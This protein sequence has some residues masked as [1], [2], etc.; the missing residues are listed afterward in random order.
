MDRTIKYFDLLSG[1][2][3]KFN[4]SYEALHNH[5][6][7]LLN[8]DACNENDGKIEYYA[9]NIART[10]IMKE[11]K[12]SFKIEYGRLDTVIKICKLGKW[13]EIKDGVYAVDGITCGVETYV[14]FNPQII[15]DGITIGQAT[16]YIKNKLYR[17]MIKGM[18]G[19]NLNAILKNRAGENM[20]S[21]FLGDILSN[22]VPTVG[23]FENLQGI[24]VNSEMTFL[25]KK[26]NYCPNIHVG[27]YSEDKIIF[28]Q[29]LPI[30]IYNKVEQC[31]TYWDHKVD[32]A[33]ISH[34]WGRWKKEK[35]NS[36]EKII[37]IMHTLPE[38]EYKFNE[39]ESYLKFDQLHNI[40]MKLPERYFWI[41]WVSIDQ[42]GGSDQTE[43]IAKQPEIFKKAST[44]YCL[45]R[46]SVMDSVLTEVNFG[47]RKQPITENEIDPWFTSFWTTQ[48]C[49]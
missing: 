49:K 46:T 20:S 48:E 18:N 14:D 3:D 9:F 13:I 2:A 41:D 27:K 37:G 23:R 30:Y 47:S 7:N 6:L 28:L 44:A 32:Y 1:L 45:F 42:Y 35:N 24:D 29:K 43:D 25:M 33:I 40:L 36:M 17:W 4:I 15:I 21:G 10:K 26:Q 22:P 5:S 19:I 16:G 12:E 38:L 31:V 39:C 34:T 11:T 8:S